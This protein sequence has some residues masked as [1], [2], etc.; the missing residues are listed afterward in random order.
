MRKK[1]IFSAMAEVDSDPTGSRSDALLQECFSLCRSLQEALGAEVLKVSSPKGDVAEFS[2]FSCKS[3]IGCML[4]ILLEG[5]TSAHNRGKHPFKGTTLR[6]FPG[7]FALFLFLAAG[8]LFDV[9]LRFGIDD[10]EAH[11]HVPLLCSPWSFST[12]RGS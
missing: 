12:Y 10:P 3:T 9:P 1:E 4:C 6:N 8:F 11:Y 5:T 2:K 7:Q